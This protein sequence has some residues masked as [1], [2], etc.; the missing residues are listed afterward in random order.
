MTSI[1]IYKNGTVIVQGHLRQFE[2]DFPLIKGRAQLKKCS[3]PDDTH[4]LPDTITTSTPTC[5]PAEQPP[6]SEQAQEPQLT[7]IITD[8]K[9]EFSE[10]EREL[11][12][13]SQKIQE[14][15]R[16]SPG[17]TRQTL[18]S[19]LDHNQDSGSTT[20]KHQDQE[21]RTHP[22]PPEPRG[23]THP[24]APLQLAQQLD[25]TILIDS[26]G[27]FLNEKKLFPNHKVAK[28]LC[29]NSQHAMELLSEE[30]LGSPSHIITHTGTND[31]RTQQERVSE[32]LR[33]TIEKAF[34][35]FPNSRVVI[36]T[37]LSRKDFHPDTIHRINSSVSRDCVLKPNVHL[38]HHPT[39]DISCLHDHVHLFKNTVPIFAQT[40][41]NVALNRDQSTPR[42]R[43]RLARSPP[44]PLPRPPPQRPD[45]PHRPPR[46]P[47]QNSYEPPQPRPE[48]LLPPGAP[49][50]RHNQEPHPGPL[51]YA[52]VVRRA[53]HVGTSR[54]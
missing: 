32:S 8:M 44:R 4:T 54:V 23:S 39:L 38:A 10:L 9:M 41:K 13:L 43:S 24:A 31:L 15:D 53:A 48:P 18:D 51:S 42:R 14:R 3:P 49:P 11:A 17:L 47:H 20:Q 12:S 27:K 2:L 5:P 21:A 29:P 28:L 19:H 45:L 7:H 26:N 6:S 40:L 30:R 35:T 1:I 50:Q 25:F 52:Q 34:S 37:L 22:E 16:V 36:S 33:R 46:R